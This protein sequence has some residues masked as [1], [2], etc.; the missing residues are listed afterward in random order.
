M[1]KILQFV[2]FVSLFCSIMKSEAMRRNRPVEKPCG[3]VNLDGTIEE[4]YFRDIPMPSRM[5][6]TANTLTKKAIEA[7]IENII[8]NRNNIDYINAY[9]EASELYKP[10]IISYIEEKIRKIQNSKEQW[11]EWS[12]RTFDKS[13]PQIEEYANEHKKLSRDLDMLNYVKTILK[14]SQQEN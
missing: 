1:R 10:T 8:I 4:N 2:I 7:I 3:P 13:Q 9:L 5:Q 11:G 14:E 12:R 6:H